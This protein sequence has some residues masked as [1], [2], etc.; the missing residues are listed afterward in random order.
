MKV[1]SVGLVLLNQLSLGFMLIWCHTAHAQVTSDGTTNTIV[2]PSGNNFHILDGIEKGNNLFHS[3]S[4]FSVPTGGSATFDV[5]NTPNI[6]TIFSRVTG[7]NISQIDGLI[8]TLGGNHQVSLFLMNPNGIMFGQNAKLD[9]GGSFVGTTANSIKFTDGTEFS[10]IN[11]IS[12]PLLTMSVPIGLQMGS[13]A[14]SITVQARPLQVDTGQSLVLLGGDIDLNGT[15]NARLLARD[16]Q[17]ILGSVASENFVPFSFSNAR[18]NFDF[19]GIP[20]FQTVQ[21]RNGFTVDVNGSR[22]GNIQIHGQQVN[23]TGNSQLMAN[24]TGKTADGEG[25]VVRAS[26]A[27]NIINSEIRVRLTADAQ[28]RGGNITLAAPVMQITGNSNIA[29]NLRGNETFGTLGLDKGSNITITSQDFLLLGNATSRTGNGSA[30]IT[31]QGQGG[32]GRVGDIRITADRVRLLNNAR[33]ITDVTSTPV[34][35]KAQAGDVVVNA[36]DVEIS[37]SSSSQIN[38]WISSTL[39]RETSGWGGNIEINAS[40]SVRLSDSGTIRADSFGNGNASNITIRTPDL[41]IVGTN[42]LSRQSRI[43]SSTAIFAAAPGFQAGDI[44]IETQRLRLLDGGSLLVSSETKSSS[45]SINIKATESV[46]VIGAALDDRGGWRISGIDASSRGEPLPNGDPGDISRINITTDTLR[47]LNSGA[48]KSSVTGD[49]IGG[50]IS[51]NA[52]TIEVGG[53]AVH[54]ETMPTSQISS[55]A[56]N[57]L[58]PGAGIAGNI[59]LTTNR[60]FVRDGGLI[61]VSGQDQAQAGNLQITAAQSINLAQNSSLSAVSSVGD[62][63][64]INIDLN[65]SGLLYLRDMSQISTEAEGNG[66]GGNININHALFVLGLENSDIVANAFQG[67]GGNINITT[68]GIIGLEFRNTLTPREDITND[69][70]ASSQFSVNGTVQINNVG[71]DPNSG[72][73]ELPTN[74]SDPSQQIANACDSNQGSS[75]IATGRGGI[76]Q[77]PMQEVRSDRTWSDTRDISAFQNT[78]QIQA[79]TPIQPQIPIQATSW[80]RNTQGKIELIAD[81]SSVNLQ[82]SLT[83]AAVN[84]S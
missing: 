57:P 69:I 52:H 67:R 42:G 77:N 80:H 21:L 18:F 10:A 32:V 2:N 83:C 9:I 26:D 46:E 73:V 84:K 55:A 31:T 14:S 15:G 8:Q 60:L 62:G 6:T 25:V 27:L 7:G 47:V 61:S 58:T 65:S 16:G 44:Q 36:G 37:G 79:Q 3:F 51:I 66:N 5:T 82:P 1:S 43:S 71:I 41:E 17:V 30:R 28:G 53:R 70:T 49:R 22:G 63:G 59:S 68:Q 76:P 40:R 75:F 48:I 50:D 29:T 38:S 81:K 11:P 13:S 56:S 78:P 34:G 19:S 45:G 4:N 20:T 23:I 64:N 54:S 72:V 39:E 33:V 12:P 35:G 24:S 74:V